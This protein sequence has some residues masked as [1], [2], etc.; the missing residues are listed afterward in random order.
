MENP[1]WVPEGVDLQR[2][3]VA[4]LYDYL[5]GGT[6]NFTVDRDLAARTLT[7]DTGVRPL[8]RA[9][10]AFLGRAVRFLA[11]AGIR[12]F[13]DIGSGIPTAGNVHE[14]AQQADPEA[15]VVY[16]DSDPVAVAHSKAIL[17]GNDRATIIQADLREPD[18]IL[19]NPRLE[20][21]L[22]FEQP[23]AI[24]LVAMLHYVPEDADP[25]AV[26]RQLRAM[27]APGSY[28]AISHAT[29]ENPDMAEH[30][31][32]LFQR[33]AAQLQTRSRAEILDMFGDMELVEP[34]LV[35]LHEWRPAPDAEEEDLWTIRVLGGIGRK[36][37]NATRS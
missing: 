9:N 7:L 29:N 25:R 8:A 5:L 24:L 10:R 26:T 11:D 21:M 23:V 31:Q 34:G 4:R 36:D 22:D 19:A 17:D 16:V 32:Q 27:T 12:Q 1:S 37:Q 6:H 28:L 15:R 33:A 30:M 2:P 20:A 18:Q 13:L 14:V 3:S 35:D